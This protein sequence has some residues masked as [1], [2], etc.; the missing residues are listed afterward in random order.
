M[1]VPSSVPITA[2][3]IFRSVTV[4][5]ALNLAAIIVVEAWKKKWEYRHLGINVVMG[6]KRIK[7]RSDR[8]RP[9]K[10]INKKKMRRK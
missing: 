10:Y 5:P 7:E 8:A 4:K 9:K 1:T 6:N 3:L 2:A